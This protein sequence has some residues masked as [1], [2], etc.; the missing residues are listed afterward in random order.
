MITVSVRNGLKIWGVKGTG[1][2]GSWARI[3]K[4]G[5]I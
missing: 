1:D 2:G 4:N 3:C 5:E